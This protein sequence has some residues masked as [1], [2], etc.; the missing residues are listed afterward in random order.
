MAEVET[1]FVSLMD[2]ANTNTDDVATVM[3]RLPAV[4]IYT[5]KGESVVGSQ[6]EP[7]DG[8]PPLIR[9]KFTGEIMDVKPTD[10]KVDPQTL[11]GRKLSETYTLWPAELEQHI[12]LLKGR[13]QKVGLPNTGN[14]G[15]VEGQAPGWLD[16]MTGHI[17]QMRV[18]SYMSKGQEQRGYDWI[19]AAPTADE[20]QTQ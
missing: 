4:G 7:Q 8:K 17:F 15:G 19:G 20:S 13:Y 1:G 14:M 11:I 16:G 12:G 5:M 3:S 10:K 18:Y 6:A 9:F 2:L